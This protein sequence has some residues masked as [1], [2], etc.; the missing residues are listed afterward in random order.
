MTQAAPAR[1]TAA[2]A[3]FRAAAFQGESPLL[4]EASA[5]VDAAK[6]SCISCLTAAMASPSSRA[7][8]P[9]DS[10]S[11]RRDGSASVGAFWSWAGGGPPPRRGLFTLCSAPPARWAANS[12]CFMGCCAASHTAS[13][14]VSPLAPGDGCTHGEA[15]SASPEPLQ[16]SDCHAKGAPLGWSAP[17]TRPPGA[18]PSGLEV[19]HC[20]ESSARAVTKPSSVAEPRAP[21]DVPCCCCRDAVAP[22]A[23]SSCLTHSSAQPVTDCELKEQ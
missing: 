20:A 17:G 19:S 10:A 12:C 23:R 16:A 3:V 11:R 8:G 21:G 13:T 4:G 15:A 22:S 6:C 18:S 2:A 7:L 14:N 9:G 5:G 1:S